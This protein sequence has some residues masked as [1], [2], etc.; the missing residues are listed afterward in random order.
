[1]KHSW[2]LGKIKWKN[3]KKAQT[4]AYVTD[5]EEM[6]GVKQRKQATPEDLICCHLSPLRCQLAL[7]FSPGEE[8]MSSTQ[9]KAADRFLCVSHFFAPVYGPHSELSAPP[10]RSC[11]QISFS[12]AVKH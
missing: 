5:R 12:W 1:M 8:V 2:T 6:V 11:A 10:P 7:Y 3:L 9:H 4:H